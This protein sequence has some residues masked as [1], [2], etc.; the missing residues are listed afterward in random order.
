MLVHEDLV[1]QVIGGRPPLLSNTVETFKHGEDFLFQCDPGLCG[2]TE[3][4]SDQ[5]PHDLD[6]RS[7][8]SRNR[9]GS[10]ASL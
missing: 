3:P 2:L 7:R 10:S 4:D 6:E 9:D 1:Q 8:R 5:A